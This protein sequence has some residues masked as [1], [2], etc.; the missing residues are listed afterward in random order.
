M[1]TIRLKPD[2]VFNKDIFIAVFRTFHKFLIAKLK[3]N[4][5][6]ISIE[7]TFNNKK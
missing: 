3:N 1:Y 4:S 6:S 2:C 5:N 7:T